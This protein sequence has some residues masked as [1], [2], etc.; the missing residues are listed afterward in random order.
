MA[1]AAPKLREKD[2]FR[3]LRSL[4]WEKIAIWT[5]FVLSIYFLRKFFAVIFL[6]FI[7]AYIAHGIIRW[8]CVK[9]GHDD[10]SGRVWRLVTIGTFLGFI[11]VVNGLSW[12][13][14]PRVMQQAEKLAEA[15]LRK[16]P[17]E[18]A[19]QTPGV[20]PSGAGQQTPQP[21]LLEEDGVVSS[22][23]V[24]ELL[25]KALP[26]SWV[27]LQGSVYR[28]SY[29]RGVDWIT[30]TANA[31]VPEAGKQ[32]GTAMG[33]VIGFIISLLVSLIFSFLIVWDLPKL[34]RK[35]EAL[36]HSNL[37]RV[38]DEIAPGVKEFG[39]GMGQAFQAQAV[40]AL[41][42]TVLT[43]I[44]L[45]VLGIPM[46]DVL[47]LIVFFCSFIPI[48]GMFISTVPIALLALT[49]DGGGPG[50]MLAAIVLVGV[51]HF[52]E[53][54]ILNPR[55][56]G[57]VMHMHPLIVLIVLF[58]AETLFGLWGVILAVPTAQFV[59]NYWIKRVHVQ[60]PAEPG[61]DASPAGLP[62]SGAAVLPQPA[63]ATLPA[64]DVPP[65]P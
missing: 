16:K 14:A 19:A 33:G 15:T 21:E 9:L 36:G 48:V 3:F 64:P 1:D 31:Y 56:Y 52:V 57:H 61:D 10:P 49:M 54:Y 62:A 42:N 60:I 51:I 18:P 53:A 43:L 7:F 59:F 55:I 34:A 24:D 6:T 46:V 22:A 65:A 23:Q 27:P 12:Y 8:I 5:L 26:A 38:Y 17:V 13:I 2:Q 37:K 30:G 63:P 44:G 32:I 58:L 29:L 25:R 40:I 20:P 11:A 50:M 35:V 41:L 4:P 47:S 45:L 39:N 28:P